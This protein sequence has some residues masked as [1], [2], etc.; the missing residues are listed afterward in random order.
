MSR[1]GFVGQCALDAMPRLAPCAPF[2]V[3]MAGTAAPP[4]LHQMISRF[5]PHLH[6][7][8]SRGNAVELSFLKLFP[9]ADAPFVGGSFR[10]SGL[11]RPGGFGPVVFDARD[12]V[13]DLGEDLNGP[14]GIIRNEYGGFGCQGHDGILEL[15]FS[16]P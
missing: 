6:H 13:E 15:E 4:L 8:P 3:S 10:E 16:G 5:T 9:P 14:L 2:A 7:L 1:S 11:C 12:G